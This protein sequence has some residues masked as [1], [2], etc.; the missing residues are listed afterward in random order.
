MFL[1]KMCFLV[2]SIADCVI[3]PPINKKKM[4]SERGIAAAHG[5]DIG[6]KSSDDSA[7]DKGNRP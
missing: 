7:A 4:I 2:T 3:L 1:I 5:L 6:D